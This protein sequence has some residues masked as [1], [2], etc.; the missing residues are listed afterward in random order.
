MDQ[1]ATP[2]AAIKSPGF[3]VTQAWLMVLTV[4]KLCVALNRS[5]DRGGSGS[6]SVN[7]S[8]SSQFAKVAVAVT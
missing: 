3:E 4:K 2:S 7:W 1:F 8:E 5:C 6:T